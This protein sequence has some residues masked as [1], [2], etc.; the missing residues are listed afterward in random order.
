MNTLTRAWSDRH[1]LS[2]AKRRA[3]P[4]SSMSTSSLRPTT[5]NGSAFGLAFNECLVLAIT[6]T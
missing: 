6:A 4:I 1:A 5:P 2:Q 3:A